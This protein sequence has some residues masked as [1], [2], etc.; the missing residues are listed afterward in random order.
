M[1][2][3]SASVTY[4]DD[5]MF[6]PLRDLEALETALHRSASGPVVIFKHSP[7]CGISAQARED[8]LD[9]SA[10]E[11]APVPIYEVRVREH[12]DVSDAIAARFRLRHESPQALII[13]D[14]RVKWH[15]SH[16]HV[17][18]REVQAA[19]D[20]LVTASPRP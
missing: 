9:W 16:F 13:E 2:T 8:L 5:V 17:N 12:R 4:P 15:G 7:T 6:Q 3:R 11:P 19:L 14:G 20:T 18:A 10:T 1:V